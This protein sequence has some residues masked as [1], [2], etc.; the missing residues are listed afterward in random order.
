MARKSRI[1]RIICRL[2][3]RV[4]A[5]VD[6]YRP[7]LA[8][9]FT[10]PLNGQRHR[11]AAVT[12][13]FRRIG[14]D[15]V[16]ETGTHRGTSTVF[17][18][19]LTAAPI[20]TIEANGRFAK[21]SYQRLRTQA[22]TRVI[23]GDSSVWLRR[24][25]KGKRPVS[26]TTPFFYLDAHGGGSLPLRFEMLE[27]TSCWADFCA[28]VDDFQVPDDP[29]YE[30]G[31]YGPGFAL[32]T[33]VLVGLDLAGVHAFWPSAKAVDD[34]GHRCGMLVLARGAAIVEG[35]RG[36]GELREDTE[37]IGRLRAQAPYQP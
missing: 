14:F 27:V 18:R 20:I 3:D 25:A 19:T 33:D 10:G 36:I 22:D 1:E 11:V 35:L 26:T 2:P 32:T 15:L 17:F 30:F 5:R 24:L 34:T 21:Y 13:M 6:G 7:G 31:A 28:I 9:G 23:H 12:E 8:A 29:A 37:L 16:V 4:A